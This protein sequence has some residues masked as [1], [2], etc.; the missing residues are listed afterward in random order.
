M[1]GAPQ[2]TIPLPTWVTLPE[3]VSLVSPPLD[4]ERV[5]RAIAQAL[6]AGQISERPQALISQLEGQ[7]LLSDVRA[8][9][10]HQ[11]EPT[12][13]DLTSYQLF[14][15]PDPRPGARMRFDELQR[16]TRAQCEP[17]AFSASEWQ[18]HFDAGS[19]DWAAGTVDAG[20]PRRRYPELSRFDLQHLF[21]LSDQ[22]ARTN[23]VT[24]PME[25]A[26]RRP[27]QKAGRPVEHDWEGA[28]DY[29]LSF[30][31]PLAKARAMETVVEWFQKYDGK[32]PHPRTIQRRLWP[33]VYGPRP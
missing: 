17:A 21:G 14:G 27:D 1:S 9:M 6:C 22:L 11:L 16:K 2:L 24:G 29:L 23:D 25:G 30:N 15:H 19:V 4:A 13:L 32:A 20:A 5:R 10:R 8:G 31:P 26:N 18:K 28:R 3:A 33:E 7:E 12:E